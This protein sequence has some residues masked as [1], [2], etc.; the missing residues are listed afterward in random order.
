MSSFQEATRAL[1]N[2]HYRFFFLWQSVSFLGTWLQ[3]TAT[4][5]LVYKLTESA[6]ILGIVSFAG[7]IPALFLT[8]FAGIIADSYSR[9]KIF[10]I[11]QGMCLIQ[12]IILTTLYFTHNL[13]ILGIIILSLFLGIANSFDMTARQSLVPSLIDRKHLSN[14]IALNS[15]M[16]N[17]ARMIGPSIAGFLIAKFHEGSCFFLNAVSYIPII[18]FLFFLKADSNVK[19]KIESPIKDLKEGVIFSWQQKPIRALLLLDGA[20]SFFCA[21]FITLLPIFCNQILHQE[22]QGFGVLNGA[23]G[24][25]AL[26]AA[27]FLA[28]NKNILRIN[29]IIAFSTILLSIALFSFAVSSIFF[30]SVLLLVFSGFSLVAIFAGSNTLLQ[31]M[32]PDKLRG[33][34]M[35][36]FSFMLMGIYPLGSIFVGTVAESIGAQYAVLLCAVIT[37][38]VGISFILKLKYLT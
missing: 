25:G 20:I 6:F 35:S 12:A 38:F 17:S 36:L 18:I 5:W 13:T 9:K 32:S 3:N 15:S 22:A 29:K 30:V 1:Q 28:V 2:K 16:F 24:I 4:S 11:T 8:P 34:I 26:L 10:M 23:A 37:F 33:R 19:K 31:A 27:L 14:A 21:P 7:S